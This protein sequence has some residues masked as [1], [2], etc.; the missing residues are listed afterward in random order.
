MNQK[1]LYGRAEG[2]TAGAGAILRDILDRRDILARVFGGGA[3]PNPREVA[4]SAS[5]V[6]LEA[7]PAGTL[8]QKTTLGANDTVLTPMVNTF[9]AG[10]AQ[11]GGKLIGKLMPDGMVVG[12]DGRVVGRRN[13]KSG[14]VTAAPAGQ[15]LHANTTVW[16]GVDGGG[17][18]VGADGQYLG[19]KMPDGSVVGPTGIVIGILDANGAIRSITMNSAPAVRPT[20]GHDQF[21]A[22]GA[23][24]SEYGGMAGPGHGLLATQPL[25]VMQPKG[26]EL[27]E[28][29]QDT[30]NT[31]P[32]HKGQHHVPDHRASGLEHRM[33]DDIGVWVSS[34]NPAERAWALD[35]ANHRA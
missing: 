15:I 16:P 3:G 28:A 1:L 25:R 4:A 20:R 6:G 19:R 8:Y 31:F 11:T 29:T 35:V 2:A 33:N 26:A 13:P 10:G 5:K 21:N 27:Y 17:T 30:L 22:G 18:T 24:P 12:P 14:A 23:P 34:S 32:W 7:V 9:L